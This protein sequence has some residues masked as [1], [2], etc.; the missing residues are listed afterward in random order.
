[1]GS[2]KWRVAKDTTLLLCQISLSFVT[3]NFEN[4]EVFVSGHVGRSLFEWSRLECHMSFITLGIDVLVEM[5]F[6]NENV[7]R[8]KIRKLC[9]DKIHSNRS[10]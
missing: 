8:K 5:S 1:M 10:V 9:R 4:K 7:N 6:V 3:T 2:D